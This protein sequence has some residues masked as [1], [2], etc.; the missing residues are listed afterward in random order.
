MTC[1]KRGRW[2]HR[3]R[4][5]LLRQLVGQESVGAPDLDAES[6]ARK[7]ERWLADR[8]PDVEAPVRAGIVFVNPE[9]TLEADASPAPAFYGKSVKRWLRGSGK[10]KP[11]PKDVYRRLAEVLGVTSQGDEE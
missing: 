10:L 2:K 4:G 11:L 8:L 1:Q 7:L 9:V 3:Q 5:R 6:Q